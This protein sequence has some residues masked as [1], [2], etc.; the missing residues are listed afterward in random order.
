MAR[1]FIVC[2]V[3]SGSVT[4]A[5]GEDARGGF[6]E[7]DVAGV[8]QLSLLRFCQTACLLTGTQADLLECLRQD[9]GW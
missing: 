7:F 4:I 1:F 8:I 9:V 6:G 2:V 3:N 5:R